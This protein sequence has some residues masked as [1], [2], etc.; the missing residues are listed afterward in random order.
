[1]TYQA[2]S[3]R[4][5]G[6]APAGLHDKLLLVDD[7]PGMIQVLGRVLAQYPRLRFATSGEDALQL[8]ATDPPDLILL[9]AEMP[10]MSG[11]EVCA[12][13]KRDPRLANSTVIFVTGHTDA[14]IE[15]SVFE[16][17]AADFISKPVNPAVVCA[18]VATHLRMRRM[19]VE[20]ER[21]ARFDALT[22]V[23]NRRVFDERL[24]G[25]CARAV[26]HG[27]PL[28]LLMIDVDHFK[29][30]NDHHGHPAGDACLREVAAMLAC[31]AQ[32]PDDLLARYGG[33]EFTL[34]LPQTGAAGAAAVARRVLAAM[35]KRALPH[36]N[37]PTAA[38]VTLSVGV[39]VL[40]DWHVD[41]RQ[42][43][44]PQALLAAA[45][46]ALYAAK[47]AGRASAWQLPLGRDASQPLVPSK[48][49]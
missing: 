30:F 23:A 34:L 3:L 26:R 5:A 19:T 12:T 37:S 4:A 43:E 15:A 13:L 32:R 39:A 38:H 20:L 25:E 17:G 10:G 11:F 22:G 28:S 33:E 41:G 42:P 2:S 8:A 47:A 27:H 7:D 18:R 21:L 45:D 1:M 36:G 44:P 46:R 48:A 24:E 29:R 49:E 31:G 9:D 14:R 16:L 40:D 6:V 35:A